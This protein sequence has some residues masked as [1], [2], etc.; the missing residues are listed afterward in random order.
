M[1]N[2]RDMP[3]YIG[4]GFLIIM[5][6]WKKKIDK[7]LMRGWDEMVYQIYLNKIP[8]EFNVY[9]SIYMKYWSLFEFYV[10][11]KLHR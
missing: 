11:N 8:Y 6:K 7:L 5:L 3:F 1:I 10:A 9:F 4:L 2:T